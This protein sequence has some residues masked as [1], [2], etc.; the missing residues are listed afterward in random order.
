MKKRSGNKIPPFRQLPKGGFCKKGCFLIYSISTLTSEAITN[1]IAAVITIPITIE[2]IPSALL[3]F[4]NFILHCEEKEC[5]HG[6]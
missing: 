2:N 4:F 3:L 6:M 1:P 5:L